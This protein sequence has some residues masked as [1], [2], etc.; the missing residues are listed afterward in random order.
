MKNAKMRKL[1]RSLYH[2]CA[3]RDLIVASWRIETKYT[4]PTH[5]K[6]L[7][8][9]NQEENNDQRHDV[10]ICTDFIFLRFNLKEIQLYSLTRSTRYW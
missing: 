9:G 8:E 2:C 4:A 10:G 1:I 6:E 7:E 3:V 5:G